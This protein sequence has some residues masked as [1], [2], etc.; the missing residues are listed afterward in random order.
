MAHRAIICASLASGQSVIKN[1]TYSNDI[2]A[3]MDA[4]VALGAAI[5]KENDTL[6]INGITKPPKNA[7]VNCKESGSTVRFLIPI[8]L[9]LGVNCTFTGEGRLPQRPLDSIIRCLT[10]DSVQFSS[11][12]LPLTVCGKLMAGKFEID[13]SLSSQFITGLLFALPLLDYDS[14][15]VLTTKLQSKPYVDMTID[16]LQ[17]FG[18]KVTATENGYFIKGRQQYKATDYI[19]EGD[20]SNAAFFLSLGAIGGDITCYGLSKN[21]LQGDKKIIELLT[22]FGANINV[23]D[24]YIRVQKDKLQCIRVDMGDIPDLLPILSVLGAFAGGDTV[25]Y[26]AERIRLKESD[27]IAAMCDNLSKFG[28]IAF[29]EDDKMI[30]KGG[31]PKSAKVSGYNDHR[32]VMASTV[33]ASFCSGDSEISDANAVNKSYNNFFED[34]NNVGGEAYVIN[35]E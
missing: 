28:I 24:D 25:L 29:A 14:E 19:V 34:F 27:R 6:I 18:I 17:N 33:L 7:T 9:S 10:S 15:I 16:T 22:Q 2:I 30:I 1:I 3:T 8:A 23:S 21:S 4:M 35:V 26:N 12:T 13:G 31:K 20:Y 5:K 32:I 11:S